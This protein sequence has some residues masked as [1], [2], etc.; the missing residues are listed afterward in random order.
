MLEFLFNRRPAT[1][2]KRDFNTGVFRE[3]CETFRKT[4]FSRMPPVATFDSAVL[5]ILLLVPAKIYLLKFRNLYPFIF[6]TSLCIAEKNIINGN[7]RL[8]WHLSRHDK[9]NGKDLDSKFF[10]TIQQTFV[11]SKKT[12]KALEKGV[13]Y[14]QR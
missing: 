12:I 10:C 11:R 8:S 7:K 14:V 1:L 5:S 6:S 4:F 3:N 9:R 13:K 2:L